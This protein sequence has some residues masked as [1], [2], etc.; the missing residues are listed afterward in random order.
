MAL[1]YH[2]D[3]NDI[4]CLY[5][6]IQRLKKSLIKLLMPIMYFLIRKCVL[7]MMNLLTKNRRVVS[8]N[9]H[10]KLS[11]KTIN[12]AKHIKTLEQNHRNHLIINI[13]RR[14]FQDHLNL[15]II[16]TIHTLQRKDLT[17]SKEYKKKENIEAHIRKTTITLWLIFY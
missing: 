8:I 10:I 6:F 3:K 7:P 5:S 13:L 17:I 2:P 1:R 11:S 9:R 15:K 4:P 16:H 12:Q 14:I